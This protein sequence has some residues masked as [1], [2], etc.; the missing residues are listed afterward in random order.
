EDW[1]KVIGINLT[2]AFTCTRVASRHLLKAKAK[3]RIVNITSVVGE[4]GNGGQTAYAAATAGLIGLTMASAK[5]LASRGVTVNAVS[6][7]YSETDRTATHLPEAA[8]QAHV[9]NTPTGR[10]GAPDDDAPAVAYR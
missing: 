6:P 3:G 7:G 2:G 1:D 4:M 10:I 5:E 9:A 8:K